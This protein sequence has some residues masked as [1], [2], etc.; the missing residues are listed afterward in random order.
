FAFGYVS[1]DHHVMQMAYDL[2]ANALYAQGATM[3]Q[4]QTVP[5]FYNI[6]SGLVK[7]PVPDAPA[8]T[9]AGFVSWSPRTIFKDASDR[10]DF[11]FG[12]IVSGMGGAD[13]GLIQ[14]AYSILPSNAGFLGGAFC[15]PIGKGGFVTEG[16]TIENIPYQYAV[17]MLTGWDLEYLCTDHHV[18]EAGVV[19]QDW[20]YQPPANGVGGK[21]RY[22]LM[23]VLVDD[24]NSV[25]GHSHKVSVLGFKP[26]MPGGN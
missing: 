15:S 14:P 16:F 25:F 3:T 20:D 8:D 10:R 24:S 2:S 9:A 22:S 23:S 21:L 6:K 11:A 4:P 1:G 26:V 17:P 18:R 7:A 13:V 12:E 19:I 5:Q